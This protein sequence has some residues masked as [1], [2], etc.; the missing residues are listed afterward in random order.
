[1]ISWIDMVNF[2]FAVCGMLVT[3][4]GLFMSRSVT[5]L[6]RWARLFF[7]A[8]FSIA[9]AYTVSDLVSQ[10]S[11]LFLGPQYRLLSAAAVFGESLLSSLLMPLMTLYLLY[12]LK[13]PWRKS[14]SFRLAVF[15]WGVYLILLVVNLFVPEFYVIT[16]QNVYQRKPLYPV[17]LVPPI[18]LMSVNLFV[19]FR[20]WKVF[21]RRQRQAFAS[22]LLIPLICML[23]Q[24]LAYGLL[25]IVI[26]NCSST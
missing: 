24:S 1:M 10:I 3:L 5:P 26:G 6:D 2:A 22:Y 25:M 11:L 4:L 16:G 20:N 21:T 7:R 8:V 17:L 23:L 19:L 9:L 13:K 18:L 15:L 14:L 12:S